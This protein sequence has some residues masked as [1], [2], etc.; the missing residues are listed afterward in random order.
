MSPDDIFSPKL[1]ILVPQYKENER[2][3][4]P[5]LDSIAIQQHVDLT[6]DVS[7]IIV[8]DGTDVILDRMFLNQYPYR[9][10][11]ILAEHGGISAARDR[12][13]QE[14]T[15]EY[16]MWCDDDDMFYHTHALFTIF[17][18]IEKERFDVLNSAFY[19]ERYYVNNTFADFL[20]HEQDRI[21]IHGKVYRRQYLIDN[22]IYW[23]H[24][25]QLHED[26]YFNTIALMLAKDVIHQD[27]PFYLWKYREDS[28]V[29]QDPKWN[30]K[31]YDQLIKTNEA[32]VKELIRRE[33][34][35]EAAQ[36]VAF[37]TLQT[38]YDLQLP[39]W[40]EKENKEYR[41][42][43]ERRFAQFFRDYGGLYFKTPPKFR[44]E[45]A[46]GHRNRVVSF[47]MVMEI[48]SFPEWI[49]HISELAEE[50]E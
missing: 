39:I 44:A 40:H 1:Q 21:F 35:D 22:G 10:D 28:T 29:R 42:Q 34:L 43:T 12:A 48:I 45:T 3:I 24:E 16:V 30:L 25:L 17:K 37:I 31:T 23:N 47:G 19:E 13:F 49:E 50:E 32:L 18:S 36:C 7:V 4:K 15:A 33:M 38:Y 9:I 8:N 6:R 41:E 26:L 11:Y 2:V 27:T 46:C 20:L 5:L 14:A